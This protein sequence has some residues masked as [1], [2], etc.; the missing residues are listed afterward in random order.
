MCSQ[1]VVILPIDYTQSLHSHATILLMNRRTFMALSAST[2]FLLHVNAQAR[3]IAPSIWHT[4]EAVLDVLFPKTPT[5]PSAKAFNA[6]AYLMNNIHHESFDTE[7]VKLLTE[8]ALFFKR[9]FPQF[10]TQ[11]IKAKEQTIRKALND[12]YFEQ[13]FSRIIYYALEAM[14]GD[15]IY[16]GNTNEIGW[17][18]TLHV[19]GEPRPSRKYG[20]KL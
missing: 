11:N 14:L 20:E 19:S 7:D 6:L 1:Y 16:G 15:P 13:W 5:M 17:K 18:S 10:F 4:L 8:G 2:P 9:D 12:D 3:E